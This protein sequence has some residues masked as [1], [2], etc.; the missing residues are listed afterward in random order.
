MHVVPQCGQVVCMRSKGRILQYISSRGGGL[1]ATTAF[2]G[3]QIGGTGKVRDIEIWVEEEDR[4]IVE[5]YRY[6]KHNREVE[7]EERSCKKP[8][9]TLR[10]PYAA[11]TSA[12]GPAQV[13]GGTNRGRNKTGGVILSKADCLFIC[14]YGNHVNYKDYRQTDGGIPCN[15]V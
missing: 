5:E 12:V 4:S 15:E 8:R 11:P 10:D 14:I 9:Q 7:K 1:M 2:Q 6:M 3:G 13:P